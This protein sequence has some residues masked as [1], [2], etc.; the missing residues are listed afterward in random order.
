M[1]TSRK[2]AGAL[3]LGF[4]AA[5]AIAQQDA[6]PSGVQRG[7]QPEADQPAIKSGTQ[8]VVAIGINS[9]ANW[10]ILKTAVSD[11]TEFAQQLHDSF[12]FVL[13]PQQ[14]IDKAATRDAINHLVRT[15]L[16]NHLKPEDSLIFFFAGH[17]TTNV[18][19]VGDEPMADGY[20]VPYD[21]QAHD[22]KDWD[23]YLQVD[24]LLADI[25]KLPAEHILVILDAC[26][27]GLALNKKFSSTSRGVDEALE[28]QLLKNVGRTVIVS[29]LGDQSAADGGPIPN[30]SL[31][32]GLMIDGLRS[33]KADTHN[34][35][36]V[37][38]NVLGDYIQ[39]A[40]AKAEGSK[41]TPEYQPFNNDEG[42]QLVIQLGAGAQPTVSGADL[43]ASLTRNESI[44]FEKL[45]KQG[46]NYWQDDDPLKNF[47]AARSAVMKYCDNGDMW[48]CDQSA[49]SFR[50]GLGGG[51]DLVLAANLARKA[52]EAK[53]TD[54]CVQLGFIDQSGETIQPDAESA[55][56]LYQDACE[57]GNLNGCAF[58]GDLYLEG[59]GVAQDYAKAKGR[60]SP[61]HATAERS[62]A[63]TDWE[64]S[65]T[66]ASE[67]RRTVARP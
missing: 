40:V 12:K 45:K 21:G 62:M 58:L 42:G 44:E 36:A 20:I 54:A 33:G 63:A 48:G 8:Y 49:R 41:Q 11:A 13:W 6:A 31:F 30:H 19:K 25:G 9:Y 61:R 1:K 3:L 51:T 14:L 24:E 39:H 27:S 17:G 23:S 50:T 46:R 7:F 43:A 64:G 34:E 59:R 55:V 56:R 66:T 35:G 53:V 2:A 5:M 29:A 10:P 4:T 28:R 22:E 37:T 15:D 32:T 38:A 47:A 57:M 52:C 26:N 65:T 16:K 67:S 60:F 18:Y